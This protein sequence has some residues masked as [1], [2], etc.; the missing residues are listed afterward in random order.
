MKWLTSIVLCFIFLPIHAMAYMDAS[1]FKIHGL[2]D[3]RFIRTSDNVSWLDHGFGKTR[4]GSDIEGKEEN[5]FRLSE[6]ALIVSPQ[7][8]WSFSGSMH[9][10]YNDT[11]KNALDIVEGFIRYRPLS[12]SPFR[13][14]TRIGAFFPPISL[15]NTGVAWTSPYT[16]TSSAINTWVGEELRTLGG[17]FTV[18]MKRESNRL[19]FTNAIYWANDPAGTILA[20]RGWA[21]HDYKTALFDRLPLAPLPSI[22]PGAI[23]DKQAPWIEPFHEIDN[24][25][26]FYSTLVWE[27]FDLLRL[28]VIYY[29]NRGDRTAIENGQYAWETQFTNLGLRFDLFPGF[30]ILSQYMTGS[31]LM[32]VSYYGQ[33]PVDID[34]IAFYTL[35]S[36]KIGRHRFTVRYDYFKIDDKD[37]TPSD[38]SQD[39]G[40]AWTLAYVLKTIGKQRL[41]VEW[42]SIESE[43]MARHHIDLPSKS[44]ES[45]FQICYR[46]QY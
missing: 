10:Q 34:F 15:E 5:K 42:L 31:S 20:W 27:L 14:R 2:L 7:L 11:Q 35:V 28:N 1:D 9:L 45:Q 36:K 4:Y 46:I 3:G 18:E 21:M 26:G 12:M 13:V 25:P 6:A 19:S 37:Y 23:F 29:N 43:Y 17:E 39:N 8:G 22:Q 44:T 40:H 41:I 24:R 30:K 32:G 38:Y 16:I 33:A